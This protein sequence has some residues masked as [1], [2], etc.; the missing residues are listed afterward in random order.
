MVP[1]EVL[2][3]RELVTSW[4]AQ[5][6]Q[7]VQVTITPRREIIVRFLD[8]PGGLMRAYAADNDRGFRLSRLSGGARLAGPRHPLDHAPRS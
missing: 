7:D 4:F 5:E 8:E 6:G 2:A 1:S 3:L